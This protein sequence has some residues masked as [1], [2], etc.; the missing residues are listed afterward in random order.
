MVCSTLSPYGSGTADPRPAG[1]SWPRGVPEERWLRAAGLG[2]AGTARSKL[3]RLGRFLSSV[4]EMI[5][6]GKKAAEK[7]RWTRR[8]NCGGRWLGA[9]T[10]GDAPAYLP[11]AQ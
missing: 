2:A 9:A 1:P 3:C 8:V 10:A 6:L 11:T 7:R 5:H 4:P